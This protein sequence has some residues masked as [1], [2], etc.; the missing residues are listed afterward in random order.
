MDHPRTHTIDAGAGEW[1][2]VDP[3]NLV[4]ASED[5]RDKAGCRVELTRRMPDGTPTD[6]PSYGWLGGDLPWKVPFGWKHRDSSAVEPVG[7]FAEDTR[8]ILSI[9]ES[10]DFSVH[11]LQHTA[12]RR[13]DGIITVDGHADDGILDN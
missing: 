4:G 7:R 11:K 13:L 5:G 8:Q 9:T 10:G 1:F 2:F 6:D 3:G 12:T